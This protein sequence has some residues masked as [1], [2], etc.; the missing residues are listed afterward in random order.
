MLL[1]A[2]RLSRFFGAAGNVVPALR[3]ACFTVAPG[4]FVAIMGPSGSGKS[5]LMNLIGLLDGPS[6][7]KLFIAGEDTTALS[8]DRRAALR[9]RQIGFV[10]QSYNLLPRS[11]AVENVELPLVYARVPRR[12][13]RARAREL[14]AAVRLDHRVD[15]SPATL[16][17]GEQQRVAIA[18][19]LACNPAIILADEPTGALDTRT[20]QE[21]L[22]LLQ[23]LNRGGRT[24]VLV[25]HDENVALHAARV[26]RLRDGAVV[27]DARNSSPQTAT[28]LRSGLPA[29]GKESAR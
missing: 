6:S 23:A 20:G 15:H 21:V 11:T 28:Q 3:D 12:Q 1:V 9:N 19:A 4:E 7:G 29:N 25:T 10:F 2:D 26:I 5:T 8:H 22:A 18:R 13:R 24:I 16:S 17:G 14:L 27:E